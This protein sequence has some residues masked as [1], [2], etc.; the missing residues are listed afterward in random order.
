MA[1]ETRFV[2]APCLPPFAWKTPKNSAGSA[3][4]I[5]QGAFT[6]LVFIPT[7]LKIGLDRYIQVL[8]L[9]TSSYWGVV[10]VL[11]INCCMFPLLIS[12]LI[13]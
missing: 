1:R 13:A 10:E 2:L 8:R 5:V 11:C 12:G 6:G 4:Y 7:I 3:G 9:D